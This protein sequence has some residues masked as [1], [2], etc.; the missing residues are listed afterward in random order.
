MNFGTLS[1]SDRGVTHAKSFMKH[2]SRAQSI[3]T[4]T[5]FSRRGSLAQVDRSPQPP[6]DET[7]E[8][9]P[10]DIGHAGAAA[11]RGK[12]PES[13]VA[14]RF[15]LIT[16]VESRD[17]VARNRVGRLTVARWLGDWMTPPT[18]FQRLFSPQNRTNRPFIWSARACGAACFL[19]QREFS[20]Q[21]LDL[22]ERGLDLHV[23]ARL[24][25]F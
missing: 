7:R 16:P 4:R 14:E 18:G 19:H 3:A 8:I 11:D 25:T 9:D 20:A 12:L 13:G 1:R 21:V 15:S 24:K 22:S 2:R 23:I 5:F 17:D 6:C 10:E